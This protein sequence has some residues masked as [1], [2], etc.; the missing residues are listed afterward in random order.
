MKDLCSV[1]QATRSRTVGRRVGHGPVGWAVG[2]GPGV[3]EKVGKG[4]RSDGGA[5][6]GFQG[7][8]EVELW[9]N[10]KQS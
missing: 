10:R 3:L 1:R 4:Q 2:G 8:V 6:G 5:A 7:P 9:E